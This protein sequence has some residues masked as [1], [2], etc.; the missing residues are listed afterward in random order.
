MF[1]KKVYRYF[2]ILELL[3]IFRV[4]KRVNILCES[5]DILK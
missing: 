1:W 3:K 2:D 5:K 4:Y